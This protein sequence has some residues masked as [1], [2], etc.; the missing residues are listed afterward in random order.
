MGD[1]IIEK[2]VGVVV[3]KDSFEVKK[4]IIYKKKRIDIYKLLI[5]H[6]FFL[7]Y[8]YNEEMVISK[9]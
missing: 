8:I 7:L 1:L 6:F 9:I 3:M 5:L 4:T 2:N